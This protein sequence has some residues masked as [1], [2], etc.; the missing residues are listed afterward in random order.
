LILD[1]IR[2]FIKHATST[3]SSL[4]KSTAD[5]LNF[6]RDR[7]WWIANFLVSV[8][9]AFLAVERI[10]QHKFHAGSY[11]GVDDCFNLATLPVTLCLAII[12]YSGQTGKCIG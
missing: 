3:H 6:I 10:A 7:A 1:L 9:L 8:F 2:A 5:T 4:R 12:A 11:H